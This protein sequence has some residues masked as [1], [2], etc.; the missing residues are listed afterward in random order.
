MCYG[1]TSLFNNNEIDRKYCLN[2][3]SALALILGSATNSL[4]DVLIST[5]KHSP[6]PRFIGSDYSRIGWHL[7]LCV[8]SICQIE[9]IQT[10]S[11]IFFNTILGNLSIPTPQYYDDMCYS[12]DTDPELS[13]G[14]IGTM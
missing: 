4:Q 2:T 10:I 7:A 9:D 14:A 5:Q 11:D 6:T 1:Q 3:I 12:K 13:Q 8:P